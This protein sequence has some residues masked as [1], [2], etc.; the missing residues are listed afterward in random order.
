MQSPTSKEQEG[1]APAAFGDTVVN[2]V[3]EIDDERIDGIV[4]HAL[5]GNEQLELLHRRILR[6]QDRL[7]EVVSGRAWR[8]YLRLEEVTTLRL[9][10]ALTAVARQAFIAGWRAARAHRRHAW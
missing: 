9:D 3:P 2:V 5:H 8:R 6:R 10:V 7:R 4:D 1:F